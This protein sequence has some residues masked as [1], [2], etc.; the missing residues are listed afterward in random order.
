VLLWHQHT[1]LEVLSRSSN[2]WPGCPQEDAHATVLDVDDSGKPTG[3]GFFGVFDGHGGKEVAKFAAKYMV[4]HSRKVPC[5]ECKGGKPVYH[6]TFQCAVA[7]RSAEV[8][9][10]CRRIKAVCICAFQ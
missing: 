8:A 9:V 7:H 6:K 5:S 4:R 10:S 1:R 2:F 3:V